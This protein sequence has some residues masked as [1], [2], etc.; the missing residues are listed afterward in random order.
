MGSRVTKD[1]EE[2]VPRCC[3]VARGP[4]TLPRLRFFEN[5]YIENFGH[6][7]DKAEERG[8]N[9]RPKYTAEK[10]CRRRQLVMLRRVWKY[11]NFD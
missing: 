8:D 2:E 3:D 7:I 6:V 5:T 9:G 10:S 11:G 1:M 4:V